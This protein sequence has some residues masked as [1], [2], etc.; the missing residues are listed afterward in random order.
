MISRSLHRVTDQVD[1]IEALIS[2]LTSGDDQIAEAALPNLAQMGEEALEP[3]LVGLPEEVD[4]RS[5]AGPADGCTDC[6]H[7]D[8]QRQV[9]SVI[10][11]G[12]LQS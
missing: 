10:I 6:H 4:I 3:L 11:P 1:E 2:D 12:I 9:A 5:C 7:D 8:V